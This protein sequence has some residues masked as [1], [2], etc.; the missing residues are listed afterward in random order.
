MELT[1]ALKQY[2]EMK[3]HNPDCILFFRI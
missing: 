3:K 2:Q 1:P